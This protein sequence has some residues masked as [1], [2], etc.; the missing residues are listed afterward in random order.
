M[1]IKYNKNV[2]IMD[3]GTHTI[4]FGVF[5]ITKEEEVVAESRHEYKI[6]QTYSGVDVYIES[7]GTYLNDISEQIDKKLPIRFVASSIFAPTN[8][9]YLTRIDKDQVQTRIKE[10]LEKFAN[11]EKIPPEIEHNRFIELFTK[12]IETRSQV[13]AATILMN[14]KYVGMLRDKVNKLGLKFGGVYPLL[15]T[16]LALYKR[17]LTFEES[18]NDEPVVFVDIGYLTTKVNLF[19]QGQL[20]FNKVLHYGSKSFY[21]ELYDFASKS[22]EAALSGSEVES[23]LH[24][25][26]FSGEVDLVNQMGF[27][28]NDP[29]PYL[30]NMSKTLGSIFSKVNSSI[31]YFT[32]A[33]ARNFTADN[34]AFMTIRKGPTRIFFSGGIINAPEF[35]QIA[36]ENFKAKLHAFQPFDVAETLKQEPNTF[37]REEFRMKLRTE[38]HFIDCSSTSIVSLDSKATNINLVK[39]VD[40]ENEN[41]IQVLR[42]LPLVKWRL[43]LGVILTILVLQTGVNYL[44]VSSEWNKL[45]RKN[46][47]LKRATDGT[48]MARAQLKNLKLE[49]ILYKAQIGYIK[50]V[51][52]NHAYYPRVLKTLMTKLGPDIKLNALEFKSIVP[53]FKPGSYKKWAESQREKDN[54][55]TKLEIEWKMEG[56]ALQRTSI[57]ALIK[58]LTETGIF[59]IP[60]PPDQ[61]FVPRQEIK[62]PGSKKGEEEYQE[63][64]AH[65]EFSMEGTLRLDNPL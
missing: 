35:L 5:K 22:G 47:A 38:N 10:E 44:Q 60:K 9:A 24:K 30:D 55:W 29:K 12:D 57:T 13:I 46:R 1:A 14:P 23:I 48:E 53:T 49:D 3:L 43:I 65:Y 16:T 40:S 39:K 34:N 18:I 4:K 54:P 56:D 37:E 15:Q 7:I 21:D 19:F 27:D 45:K 32:S 17:L 26:G 2:Q 36:Q 33:L 42:K 62:K 11:Q 31:N 50:K 25:V 61:K 20:L 51:M 8:L 64:A 59:Y 41:P 52:E 58:K 63:I 28:I 6:P